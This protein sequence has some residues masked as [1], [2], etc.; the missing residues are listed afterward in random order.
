MS[1]DGLQL[2]DA[3]EH[4]AQSGG[5]LFDWHAC[6]LFPESWIDLV[7]VLRS[8]SA[9]LYDRLKAR[10]YSEK[11]LQENMDA[12]IM[13]VLLGEARDAFQ[14]EIVI[15]LRSNNSEDMESNVERIV[16]WVEQWKRE[17]GSE[18]IAHGEGR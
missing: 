6:D 4:E 2:L 18:V 15:E 1:L 16:S 5:Y 14:K 9:I 12:E 8:D 17:H 13:E 7:I 3:I 10:K 11:K